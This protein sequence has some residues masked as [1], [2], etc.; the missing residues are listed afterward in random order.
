MQSS[1]KVGVIGAGL[2]GA[3]IAQVAAASGAEVVLVDTTDASLGRARSAM[4]DS[5]ARIYKREDDPERLVEQALGNI[6]TSTELEA[7]ADV[8]IVVEAVFEQLDVKKAVFNELDRVCRADVV[9]ATNTSAIPVTFIASA[10]NRPEQVVGTHF[11]SPV[12]VTKLCELVRGQLTSDATLARARAFAEDVGKTCIVVNVDSAGFVTSLIGA[13]LCNDAVRIV[14]TG[15]ASVEDVDTAC[16]LGFGHPMGPFQLMDLTGLDV[17]HDASL[18]IYEETG[19]PRFL[20]PRTLVRKVVVGDI[21]RKSGRG[22][23]T[24]EEEQG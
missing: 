22:W 3:G 8:E 15:I 10:T 20:P 2:M 17:Q 7:V 4:R 9:L 18:R 12:P 24:Y 11:F 19:D 23:Y 14:E 16:R 5:L 21:G 1:R 6:R 13:A